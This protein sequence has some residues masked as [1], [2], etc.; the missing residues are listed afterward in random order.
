MKKQS[1]NRRILTRTVATPLRPEVL[2]TVGGGL[3]VWTTC[4]SA[5]FDQC[6]NIPIV[7]RP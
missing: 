1:Q 2:Q 4:G 7:L 5:G 3:E 6:D